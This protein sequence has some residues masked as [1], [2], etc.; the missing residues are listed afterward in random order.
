[1]NPITVN[2]AVALAYARRANEEDVR[3]AEQQRLARRRRSTEP[4]RTRPRLSR[5][6]LVWHPRAARRHAATG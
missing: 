1:M 3:R 4:R 2:P 6:S 5:L